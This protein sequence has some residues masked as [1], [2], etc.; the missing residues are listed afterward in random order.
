MYTKDM[1]TNHYQLCM[2]PGC[3]KVAQMLSSSL[4][5]YPFWKLV[6][7]GASQI[8]LDPHIFLLCLGSELKTRHT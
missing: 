7:L 1:N 2:N 8:S 4:H 5:R 3:S 6:S